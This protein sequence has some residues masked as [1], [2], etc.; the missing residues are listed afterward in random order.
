M[1][2]TTYQKINDNKDT[3]WM[4]SGEHINYIDY[5]ELL[6]EPYQKAL[7]VIQAGYYFTLDEWDDDTE[8]AERVNLNWQTVKQ[9]K[10]ALE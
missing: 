9:I 8:I 4:L 3:I 5:F 6:D 1:N 10:K 7:M 2:K